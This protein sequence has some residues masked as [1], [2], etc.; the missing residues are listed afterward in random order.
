VTGPLHGVRVL[1]FGRFI[2]A[3][4]C[5][6]VL[7]DLGAE[8]LRVE[9]PGGEEDR[10]L[11]LEAGNG[12]TF[13]FA[14]LARG[15]KGITLDLRRREP[16]R[17]VLGDLARWADVLVHN[18]GP[19]A[20][21]ALGLTYEEVKARR[22]DIVYAAVSCFG[23]GGRTG[24]DQMA[25]MGSGAGMLTGLEAHPP[26]R[27]GVPW[28]DYGTGLAAAVGVL[29]ALRHRDATGE[30]QSVD[31]ALLQ[32]A[33]SFTA[34]MVAEAVVAGMP[35]PRLGNQAAYLAPSNLYPC[36]DG[37]VYVVAITPGTWRALA[38][39]IDRPE[40][41]VAP[42][43]RTPR[44][45][46]D[47]RKRLDGLIAGWTG[48]R[49]VQEALADL[50]GARVPC[51]AQLTPAQVPE[52]EQVRAG[53]MLG[54]VDLEAPGLARVPVSATPVRLSRAGRPA[55]LRP[56]RPGEHN[57]EVYRDALGYSDER[58]G[59]LRAAGVI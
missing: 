36:R 1:D 28:A 38:Q 20:A 6:M 3:P 34:P 24:F 42:E 10:R 52:D 19:E 43:L 57:A 46:F 53:G 39:V 48:R 30:G 17:Q 21:G 41:A 29:A 23:P 58:L 27:T 16:A 22:P 32:T 13:T 49:T 12:E 11:G 7:T 55:P 44:Q 15:K 59:E 8:V 56:P 47:H 14:A 9:R 40:L 33:V 31:C 18:F 51:G 4:Y 35:R 26:M 5:A 50:G 54:Y 25:Q 45:R 2:A 37:H